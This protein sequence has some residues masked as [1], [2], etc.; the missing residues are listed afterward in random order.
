MYVGH[1]PFHATSLFYRGG[2]KGE[3]YRRAGKALPGIGD[4]QLV[5]ADLFHKPR[6][7]AFGLF[8]GLAIVHLLVP[9]C[10]AILAISP[11]VTSQLP[12]VA[13]CCKQNSACYLLHL[14][15]LGTGAASQYK[16][17]GGRTKPLC[18]YVTGLRRYTCNV[19]AAAV[20]QSPGETRSA[21]RNAP[22]RLATGPR[23]RSRPR[24]T[25]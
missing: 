1:S 19:P 12:F 3:T 24:Q 6:D 25:N 4:C 17:I 8:Q 20:A 2:G 16:Y 5:G 9:T 10:F 7:T 11:L 21:S 23:W 15:G 18:R 14:L 13:D 22:P